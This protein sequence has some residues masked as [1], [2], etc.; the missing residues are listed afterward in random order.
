MQRA[1]ATLTVLRRRNSTA[2]HNLAF[3]L[4][5][6]LTIDLSL[7]LTIDLAPAHPPSV[8]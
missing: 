4:T 5:I 3:D 6:D 8:Q 2:A 7:A 1:H